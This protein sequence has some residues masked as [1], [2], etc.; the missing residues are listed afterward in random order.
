M[1][2]EEGTVVEE[3]RLNGRGS[4]QRR[5]VSPNNLFVRFER[6]EVE[7]SIGDRFEQQVRL[8]PDNLAL[9]SA[10]RQWGYTALNRAASRVA[11]VVLPRS[12]YRRRAVVAR[13]VS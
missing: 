12:C 8:H 3:Q 13:I 11:S 7:Q 10:T 4:T 2:S 1:T 5:R 6:A 9:K